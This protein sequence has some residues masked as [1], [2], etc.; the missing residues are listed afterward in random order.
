MKKLKNKFYNILGRAVMYL[1]IWLS[2]VYLNF[3]L[4]KVILDNCMTVYK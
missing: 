1:I 4:L 3:N 2:A